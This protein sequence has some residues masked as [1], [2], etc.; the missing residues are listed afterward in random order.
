MGACYLMKPEEL[1]LSDIQRILIGEVPASF[2]IELIFRAAFIYFLLMISMR[3]MGKRMSSQIS[4]NEMAAVVSLA[5][6]VGIPLMNAD[7][8]LLPGVIIAIV[9]IGFQVLIAKKAAKNE[10]FEAITQD[11]LNILVTDGVMNLEAM[12]K[13]RITRERLFAQ[14]RSFQKTH[15]GSVKRLYIEANGLFS[16]V[17]EREQKPGLSVLPED[18]NDFIDKMNS[19]TGRCVCYNCGY[20]E[21]IVFKNTRIA[22]ENCGERHWVNA[23][24]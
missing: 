4:R 5:A 6:A 9:I 23:V 7:R 24:S 12:K 1:K 15:L 17:D 2:F 20:T 14:L 10:K 18:D 16:L 3:L 21:D 22:C 19:K 11:D 8:G 13:T